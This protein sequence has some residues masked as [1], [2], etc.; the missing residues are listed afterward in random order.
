MV[1]LWAV[2]PAMAFMFIAGLMTKR[3]I[4]IVNTTDYG[5]NVEVSK[6]HRVVVFKGIDPR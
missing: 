3:R 5:L 1:A 6:D 2:I 4:R